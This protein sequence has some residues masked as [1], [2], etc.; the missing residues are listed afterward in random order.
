[1]RDPDGR[2][3][4]DANYVRRIAYAPIKSDHFLRSAKAQEMQSSGLLMPFKFESDEIL[5]SPRIPFI[6]LPSEWCYSQFY[7]AARLTLDIAQEIISGGW[8]LKDASAWNIVFN[9]CAPTFC[10]HFSFAQIREKKWWAM[11]QFFH[12]FIFPLALARNHVIF[13]DEIF[14]L[15]RDGIN[16]V[17]TKKLLGWSRFLSRHWITMLGSASSSINNSPSKPSPEYR[18]NLISLCEA[19]L[20]G[21]RVSPQLKTMWSDYVHERNHYSFEAIEYKFNFVNMCFG[22]IRPN[23]V[24]DLGC[25]TGEYTDLAIG[26]GAKVIAVDGDRSCIDLLYKRYRGN[27]NVSPL[28]ADLSDLNGSRGWSANEHPSL[29]ERLSGQCDCIL[30]LG[31]VHHLLATHSIPMSQITVFF[32]S[33]GAHHLIVELI[34]PT[35]ERLLQ[36]GNNR[37]RNEPFIDL[38]QQRMELSRHFKILRDVA[39]PHSGR[40]LIFAAAYQ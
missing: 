40:R 38:D 37:N 27:K 36:L 12:H 19:M 33:L 35:D 26:C 11:G 21:L 2:L 16:A 24:L 13:P 6:S 34:P 5:I 17:R 23:R 14:R 9:G 20:G 4:F 18:S 30:A 10:D 32:K 3:E 29:I 39:I 8:E 15:S 25:N 31:L 28:V 1:M 22:E 7:D